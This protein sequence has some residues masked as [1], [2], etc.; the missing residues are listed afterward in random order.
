MAG[1]A[2]RCAVLCSLWLVACGTP[3]YRWTFQ[4]ELL[5]ADVSMD[6]G[7]LEEAEASYRQLAA[8]AWRDELLR[9]IQFRLAL[10]SERRGDLDAA[11][12]Q[13]RRIA[14]TP[15]SV[16]DDRAGEA[17][18]RWGVIETSQGR[19]IAAQRIFDAVILG[20]P[21]SA[22]AVDALERRVELMRA[23]R[24]FEAA[25]EYLDVLLPRLENTEVGDEIAYRAARIAH[26]DLRRFSDAIQRYRFVEEWF[27][28]S[29]YTD[30]SS[31]RAA[32]CLGALGD[33]EA[34][35]RALNDLLSTREVSWIMADYESRFYVPALMR[36]AEIR[37][38]QG[39]I[40]DAIEVLER[41]LD[42]YKLSLKVDDV[43]FRVIELELKLGRTDRA[44]RQLEWLQREKP[45]SRFTRRAAALLE[46]AESP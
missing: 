15:I 12:E 6:G 36:M 27:P 22:H 4:R 24:Q 11:V 38:Q 23:A 3:Q 40:E 45:E 26:E 30:D 46:P 13:Y 43:R 35:F 44:K 28:R 31:W 29:S 34:E 7:G 2:R 14:A 10:I 42:T 9:Y 5:A 16:Y 39:R 37:E 8:T 20:Y 33:E 1:R 32:Q 41:F 17:L 19:P 21:N 25:I 18:Y